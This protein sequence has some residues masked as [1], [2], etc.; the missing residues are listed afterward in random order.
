[1]KEIGSTYKYIIGCLIYYYLL[2]TYTMLYGDNEIFRFEVLQKIRRVYN[3][4]NRVAVK[5]Y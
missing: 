5:V 3:K 4:K 1:M 2:A